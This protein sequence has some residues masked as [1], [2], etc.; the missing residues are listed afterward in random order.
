[1]K[2]RSKKYDDEDEL[3]KAIREM[4][5]KKEDYNENS[6]NKEN[7][8]KHF[9]KDNKKADL[10]NIFKKNPKKEVKKKSKLKR[11]IIKLIIV[12]VVIIGI[13]LGISGHRWKTLAKDMAKNESS[14]VVDKDGKTI[15]KIGD[16]RKKEN[17]SSDEIPKDLKNAYVAI[18]DERFYKHGG[19]DVKRT[20]SAI[21]SYVIHFGSSSYGGSTIT[22]QLVKNLTGNATDSV[23]RKVNEWWKAELI[24][25]VLTK[26]EILTSY[27]NVIYTGPSIYGVENGAK[28]YFNKSAKDLSIAEC[29]FLAGINHS[30]NS[31]NPFNGGDNSTKIANRAKTVLGKMKEFN[32]IS[33]DQ[34]NE[35]A[36]EVDNGLNFKN[37]DVQ[38]KS[39][40]VYSY[41]TDALISEVIGDVEKKYDI[42]ETFATNYINMAGLTIHS[43]QDSNIQ[44]ETETECKKKK[45]ILQSQNGKDTSQAAMVIIDHKTGHV[46]ACT[47]GLGEKT[48]ARGFN[49]ATQTVRQTGSAIKPI[50]VL[51]PGIAK[52]EFTA[53]TV[54]DDT[55][56]DFENGYHPG[57]YLKSLG[58]I[59][60]RRAVESSQNIP[61]VEMM[62]K[63][64]PKN[65]MKYMKKMGVTTLTKKDEG[66]PLALGGLDKGIS[67]LQMAGA[68]ATIANDGKYI[69]PVFYSSI[70]RKDGSKLF[71]VKQ[72]KRRVFSKDVAYIVKQLLTQPVNGSSGTATYC[73]IN[74]VDVAAKTGTTDEDYDRWLCGFT[75]YYTAVTWFGY[76]QNETVNFNKRNPAGLIW[77][78][79]MSRIHSGLQTA[80]FD[81]PFGVTEAKVC[82]E[83]GKIATTGCPSTYTEYYLW[84]TEPGL[85]DKHSGTELK[86]DEQKGHDSNV[87]D[88]IKSITNEIDA[89]EPTNTTETNS[90]E[91]QTNTSTESDKQTTTRTNTTNTQKNNS[92]TQR[93]NTAPA[94]QTN[95][96]TNS[97]RNTT[98]SNSSN[99]SSENA[100]TNSSRSTEN[101]SST[102]N[103]ESSEN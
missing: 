66:L 62:E 56:K 63:I 50:A 48:E 86:S 75:P 1:M 18:E 58:N 102:Q 95:T 90:A 72:K 68:Y 64:K 80:K 52:R 8:A 100:S 57:D 97:T 15:A 78:N 47:G 35:A 20:T 44:K 73:K 41:H 4:K 17:L 11:F 94:Q 12:I 19:V 16:E 54:F 27:L 22:Q 25:D 89:P 30:P 45:Y 40:G 103:T 81:K 83:T 85:C 51:V 87:T 14:T 28:F 82:S 36:G 98:R 77:A 84:L 2:K 70:S 69:E 26:D 49:R 13:S 46:L 60:V 39:D 24:E 53:S 76:D 43:T 32:Y 88:I 101:S 92:N 5:N 33:D 59:T 6:D 7:K 71:N 93:Q 38:P 67:P 9:E 99:T 21:F 55:E 61:F 96:S 29:A 34:Y 74:G 79:V 37:G 91:S 65:S 31:Y 3:P 42:S 23:S 10:K